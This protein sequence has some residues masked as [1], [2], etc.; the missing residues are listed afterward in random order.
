MS[1]PWE[2]LIAARDAISSAPQPR[3]TG[4]I[5]PRMHRLACDLLGLPEGSP[6]TAA[7]MYRAA[8]IEHERHNPITEPLNR[9]WPP[10]EETK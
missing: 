8:E 4:P 1:D 7:D 3:W 9:T 2:D 10:T 6:L 5:H